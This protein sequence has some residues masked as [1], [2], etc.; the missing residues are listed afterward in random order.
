MVSHRRNLVPVSDFDPDRAADRFILVPK[1]VLKSGKAETL[2]LLLFDAPPWTVHEGP[3][4]SNARVVVRF[5][6]LARKTSYKEVVPEFQRSTDGRLDL[7]I[8]TAGYGRAY[9]HRL[10]Y[11]FVNGRRHRDF[12]GDWRAFERD[13][14]VVD[15]GSQGQSFTLDHRKLSL[16]S[17]SASAKQGHVLAAA[18]AKRGGLRRIQNTARRVRK[19]PAGR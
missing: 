15:H 10:C 18:Y 9:L 13:E 5:Q 19:R 1:V 14:R 11:W 17:A 12:G 8:T 16:Q 6:D 2:L 3:C 7:R 4:R